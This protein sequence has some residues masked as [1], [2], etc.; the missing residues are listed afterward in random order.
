MNNE[1]KIVDF[2]KYCQLCKYQD[3][4][5]NEFDGEQ[6]PCETCLSNPVNINSRKPIK[7]EEATE[8]KKRK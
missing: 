1:E 8:V 7:F 3:L 2:K 4:P 5:K 6:E